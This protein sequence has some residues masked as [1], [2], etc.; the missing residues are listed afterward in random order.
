MT[1]P[2]YET[3]GRLAAEVEDGEL[4]IRATEMNREPLQ[5][6]HTKDR[7][8]KPL[9]TDKLSVDDREAQEEQRSIAAE[10]Y[11]KEKQGEDYGSY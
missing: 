9:A 11:W 3:L 8:R 7:H 1:Y 6:I 4:T 5:I 2:T 10:A